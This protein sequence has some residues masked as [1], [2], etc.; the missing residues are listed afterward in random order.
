V[1]AVAR[2][3]QLKS[4]DSG[5]VQRAPSVSEFGMSNEEF[6]GIVRRNAQLDDDSASGGGESVPD[7]SMYHGGLIVEP[8]DSHPGRDMLGQ[9]QRSKINDLLGAW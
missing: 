4:V 9:S 7:D 2:D 5:T 3:C 8:S 6:D 1:A